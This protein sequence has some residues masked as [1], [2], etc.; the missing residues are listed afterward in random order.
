VLPSDTHS[1]RLIAAGGTCGLQVLLVAGAVV[2]ETVFSAGM[3]SCSSPHFKS[4]ITGAKR[5]R[6]G[7]RAFRVHGL[8]SRR[9]SMEARSKDRRHEAQPGSPHQQ[10]DPGLKSRSSECE[11]ALAA[12]VRAIFGTSRVGRAVVLFSSRWLS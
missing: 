6:D 8:C 2:I 11:P 7:A 10:V 4:S 9:L 1:Q 5:L 3:V 12:G